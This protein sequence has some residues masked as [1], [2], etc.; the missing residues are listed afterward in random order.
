[1]AIKRFVSNKDNVITNAYKFDLQN[2]AT[3]SNMG[4]SD[5]LEVFT[6]YGQQSKTS[7][8]KTRILVQF[9]IDELIAQRSSGNIPKSGSVKFHLTLFNAEHGQSVPKNYNLQVNPIAQAWDEGFGL[10]METYTDTGASNWVS[11]SAASQVQITKFT[12]NSSSAADYSGASVS[13]YEQDGDRHNFWF[14][15]NG[16]ASAPTL[17]GTEHEVDIIGKVTPTE[18][19]TAF[20]NFVDP[21][22]GFS[23]VSQDND[24]TVVN[25]STT[26]AGSVSSFSF[27]SLPSNTIVGEVTQQGTSAE[28]WTKEGSSYW[29][30]PDIKST[31]FSYS[32]TFTEGRENLDIDITGLVE[33]WVKGGT[34]SGLV[35]ASGSLLFTGTPVDN[36]TI[37]VISTDGLKREY[38]FMS[39]GITNAETGSSDSSVI[40]VDTSSGNTSTIATNFGSALKS[41]NAHSTRFTTK[42]HS[43]LV[44]LT[45]SASGFGGNTKVTTTGVTNTTL[46]TYLSGGAGSLNYGLLVNLQGTFEDGTLATSFYTKKFFARGSEFIL[47]RP[48]LEA[49]WDSAITDDRNDFYLSSSL[50]SAADNLN[51]IYLYN[52]FRGTLNNLP[53]VG[54]GNLYVKFLD[55][56]GAEITTSTPRNPITASYSSTGIYRAQVALTTNETP[57]TDVWFFEKE[58]TATITTTGNPGNNQTFSL[59]N[60]AGTS[61]TFVFK[62]DSTTVDGTLSGAN[63]IIGVQ[64]ALGSAA[65]VGDRIRAAI[66]NVSGLNITATETSGGAMTLTQDVKGSAGN[67]TID[68]SGVTTV[69]STSFTG[70]VGPTEFQRGQIVPKTHTSNAHRPDFNYV[71]KLLNLKSTYNTQEKPRLRLY[72][73][74]RDWC[75]NIYSIASKEIESSVIKSAYYKL[76]RVADDF[77]VINYGTGSVEYTKLSYDAS[78]S[79]FDLDMSILEEG[80]SYEISV[81]YKLDND[82]KEQ[83]DKFRFRVDP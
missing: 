73:R 9:P 70:G 18:I 55:K 62:T 66:N 10:D 72:I 53:S 41:L 61:T 58:A 7:I 8:E 44:A 39:S 6:I 51:S 77:T 79:Y 45:Q 69:D 25:V 40:F 31:E 22:D 24:G 67:T 76:S 43:N 29:Q 36:S 12:F 23:A 57:V 34:G 30:S 48:I 83:N 26:T 32:Q 2:R 46:N 28:L 13:L 11:A 14:K 59:K 82:Y 20:R 33:E 42:I 54:T 64:N 3:K 52:Y 75:P 5:V 16:G 78:G 35:A 4:Q 74:E 56:T 80:H 49:R 81:V 68:T 71:S 1:M 17:D 27:N 60:T 65:A 63:V 47:K 50:L 38:R 37:S 19:A 15:H 21:V